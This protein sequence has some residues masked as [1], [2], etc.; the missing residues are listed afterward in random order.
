TKSEAKTNGRT[1]W[2]GKPFQIILDKTWEAMTK[3]GFVGGIRMIRYAIKKPSA[4]MAATIF[5]VTVKPLIGLSAGALSA[6]S[7]S[8]E[9]AVERNLR[10][11]ESGG[12][13]VEPC[14]SADPTDPKTLVISCS[15][16]V[17]D[18][19]LAASFITR[20]G[21]RAWTRAPLPDMKEGL[22]R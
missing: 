6:Q 22:A 10:V 8:V 14:V 2:D 5:L 11:S 15:E 3:N 4:V 7:V 12:P 17:K 1:L 16:V 19:I 13:F 20:D 18:G 9:I 21:G